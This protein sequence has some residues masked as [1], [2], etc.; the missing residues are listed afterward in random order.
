MSQLTALIHREHGPPPGNCELENRTLQN[1]DATQVLVQ[2]LASP[3]NPADINICQGRYAIQPELP[4]IAGNEG[5]GRVLSIGSNVSTTAP[6][7]LVVAPRHLGHWCTHILVEAEEV[8]VLPPETPI[9]QA[10]FLTSTLTSAWLLLHNYVSCKPG[11]W[12]IQ[13]AANSAVGTAVIQIAAALDIHTINIVRRKELIE[14]LTAL[15]ADLVLVDSEPA[16]AQI[17]ALS[18]RPT[19]ALGINAVGGDSARELSKSLA[20]S[21]TLVTYGAMSLQPVPVGGGQLIFKD[22]RFRGFWIS[23]WYS[24]ASRSD[25][26]SVFDKIIPLVCDRRLKVEVEKNYPL[27]DFDAGLTHAQQS[28]RHGKICFHMG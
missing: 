24:Q 26:Q 2:I 13:N 3:I 28:G 18:C 25:I 11:D 12:I 21:G 4:G 1:P 6:G 16:S 9:D 5:V 8:F 22:L 7:D 19:L 20:S 14:P 10:A 15:G 17:K 27:S 23:R